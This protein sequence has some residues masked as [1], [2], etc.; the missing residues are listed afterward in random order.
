M[1]EGGSIR[2]RVRGA[3]LR[4]AAVA[5]ATLAATALLAS[6][7][8]AEFPYSR[9]ATPTGFDDLWLNAGQVP[10]DLGGKRWS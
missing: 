1:G 2:P 8:A 3:R 4:A 10:S 9:N 5:L 6:S 7:A